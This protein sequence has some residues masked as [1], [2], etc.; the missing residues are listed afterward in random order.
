M[1][2]TP[3]RRR[4]L[5]ACGAALGSALSGCLSRG[6]G[7]ADSTTS[8][9]T[10][11]SSNS[12]TGT[13]RDPTGSVDTHV[14][15]ASRYDADVTLAVELRRGGETVQ[16]QTQTV[17]SGINTAL[18]VRVTEPGT[19]TV[20]ASLAD[21][22]SARYEWTVTEEYRG[23][24]EVRIRDDGSLGFR[25]YLQRDSCGSEQLPY[26]VSGNEETWSASTG[27]VWNESGAPVTVSLAV[28]HDGTTFFECTF[29]LDA[30]QTVELGELTKTAGEYDVAVDVDGGGGTEY[31][32]RIPADYSWPEL[33]VVVPSSRDPIAGCGR[34]GSIEVTVANPTDQPGTAALSLLR[35]GESVSEREVTVDAGAETTVSLD[36][37]IGDFYTLQAETDT[38]SGEA[39]VA[40][41]YCYSQYETTVTLGSQGPEVESTQR[42]CD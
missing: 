27:A 17:T 14:S 29:D 34:G 40:D 39:E 9:T 7:P 33:L 31:D 2:P 28:S 23:S 8:T 20:V 13:T 6:T 38:G 18:D 12:T 4:L 3:S 35:D 26:R 11:R 10:D 16:E 32:W 41:C 15:A 30:N 5:C 37:P 19:Y 42:I 22:A 1:S 21:G 24:L 25:E 36:T